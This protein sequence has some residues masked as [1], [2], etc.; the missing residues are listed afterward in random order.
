MCID[1]CAGMCAG[2]CIDM[3]IDMC[4]HVHR[5]V[6]GHAYRRLIGHV[7]GRV[8][9]YVYR[10]AHAHVIGMCITPFHR[11]AFNT[12]QSCE[13]H[14]FTVRNQTLKWLSGRFLIFFSTIEESPGCPAVASR[15]HAVCLAA[16]HS[17]CRGSPR[18]HELGDADAEGADPFLVQIDNDFF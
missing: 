7:Y 13:L 8:H 10:H 9:R 6:Y 5:H 17:E 3:C 12:R 1:M 4:R 14:A 16:E 11:R 2:M 18:L 15:D